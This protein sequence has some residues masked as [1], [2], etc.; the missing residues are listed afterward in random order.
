VSAQVRYHQARLEWA[1]KKR[2]P[3]KMADKTLKGLDDLLDAIKV[4]AQHNTH[5]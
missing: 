4:L 3:Y 5:L 2:T 1:E